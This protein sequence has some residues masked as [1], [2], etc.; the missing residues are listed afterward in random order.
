[1]SQINMPANHGDHRLKC[2][3]C[4]WFVQGVGGKTCQQTRLAEIDT[5]ACIEYQ[6]YRASAFDQIDKDK[7]VVE[8]RKTLLVW[9]EQTIKK[10]AAE[11]KSYR[12]MKDDVSLSD[13]MSYIED[14][15]LAEL[16]HRFEICQTYLDRLLDLR[17][18]V[19]DKNS[20]LQSLAK[21]IQAYLITNYKEYFQS[22]KNDT[23]RS[24]FF[25]ACTPELSHALEAMDGLQNKSEMCYQ[26]LKDTH[27]NLARK[28]DAIL[29][30]W[31]AKVNSVAT[32][33]R[34]NGNPG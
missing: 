11:I 27:F 5:R 30:L 32:R 28:Q 18:E 22:L 25:R 17:Y 2:G 4:K 13:P 33:T 1:M 24:A 7:F 26:N 19:I 21:D 9:T 16:G 15:K 31:D 23:E 29:K 6:P 10:Y 3:T 20:E 12:L 8:M 14:G 34:S